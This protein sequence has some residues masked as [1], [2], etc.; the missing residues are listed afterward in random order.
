MPNEKTDSAGYSTVSADQERDNAS[1]GP[2][3]GIGRAD[4]KHGISAPYD[5]DIQTQIAA[6]GKPKKDK[7]K[8][9]QSGNKEDDKLH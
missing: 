6:K 3:T 5:E 4:S 2:T 8:N 7:S 9:E 1:K